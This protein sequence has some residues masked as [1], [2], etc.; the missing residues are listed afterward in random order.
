MR[1]LNEAKQDLFEVEAELIAL[2]PEGERAHAAQDRS[3]TTSM[4]L[5]CGDGTWYWP[6]HAVVTLAPHADVDRLLELVAAEFGSRADWSV[7]SVEGSPD[8]LD[9]LREDGLRFFVGP[10][11]SDGEIR[12]WDLNSFS[13]C[14]ALEGEHDPFAEY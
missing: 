11:G 12:F 9:L 10:V 1:S 7:S 14:F 5:D 2:I 3:D 4:L 13:A 6:G 8:R